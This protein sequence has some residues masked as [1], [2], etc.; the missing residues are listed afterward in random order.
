R[1]PQDEAASARR[2]F[3]MS[4]LVHNEQV[5]LAATFYNNLGA[6]AL[7]GVFLVPAFYAAYDAPAGALHPRRA[8]GGDRPAHARASAA[9]AAARLNRARV[10]LPAA[11]RAAVQT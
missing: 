6:A 4:N 9:H 11:A 2:I 10:V 3:F 1:P 5:K 7:L 8:R